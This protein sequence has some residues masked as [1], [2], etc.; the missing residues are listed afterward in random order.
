MRAMTPG[1][2]AA[3]LIFLTTPG[4]S[5]GTGGH[6]GALDVFSFGQLARGDGHPKFWRNGG[7]FAPVVFSFA[8]APPTALP[9]EATDPVVIF[10][11]T[12]VQTAPSARSVH[13]GPR[14][15]V[16]GAEA[17]GKLPTIIYGIPPLGGSK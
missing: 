3:G 9:V 12:Y 7:I 5:A 2:L 8:S 15:I 14:I 4:A 16:I 10:A 13:S 1:F 11:P 17:A 6:F